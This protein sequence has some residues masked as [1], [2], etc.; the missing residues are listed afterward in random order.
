MSVI[1]G[2]VAADQGIQ[3]DERFSSHL[4][5]CAAQAGGNTK[6]VVV[7]CVS[8]DAFNVNLSRPAG[9]GECAKTASRVGKTISIGSRET[10]FQASA[11]AA[12]GDGVGDE[13]FAPAGGELRSPRDFTFQID[14]LT[15]G[16]TVAFHLL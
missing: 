2:T 4:S 9:N 13:C 10:Q 7:C 3:D 5:Y 8:G 16:R 6:V 12:M 14:H 1:T 11:P 15:E